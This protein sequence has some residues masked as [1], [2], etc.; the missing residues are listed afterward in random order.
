MKPKCAV[1][2]MPFEGAKAVIALPVGPPT[3]DPFS[4]EGVAQ[5]TSSQH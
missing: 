2:G 4:V 3:Q 5:W 1:T